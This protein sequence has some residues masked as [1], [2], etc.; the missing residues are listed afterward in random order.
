MLTQERERK[1][2]E[3]R[4]RIKVNRVPILL[5]ASVVSIKG[6]W[7]AE[8]TEREESRSALISREECVLS[9][10][11]LYMSVAVLKMFDRAKFIL[12]TYIL[13]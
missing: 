12:C 9:V 4:W 13:K 11:F 3:M 1:E 6:G 10:L 8:C 5:M 7:I 2:A